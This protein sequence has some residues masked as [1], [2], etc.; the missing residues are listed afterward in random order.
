MTSKQFA[1]LQNKFFRY[2]IP[3]LLNSSHLNEKL[4]LFCFLKC[5]ILHNQEGKG[6]GLMG[7]INLKAKTEKIFLDKMFRFLHPVS[8]FSFIFVLRKCRGVLANDFSFKS[9]LIDVLTVFLCTFNSLT[10]F[11]SDVVDSVKKL[12]FR[13]LFNPLSNSLKSFFTLRFFLCFVYGWQRNFG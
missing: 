10:C 8:L 1:C 2:F 6:L 13:F 11:L 9:C 3:F 7:A 5:P 12:S 4:H